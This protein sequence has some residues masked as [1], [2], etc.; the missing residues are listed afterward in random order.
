MAYRSVSVPLAVLIWAATAIIQVAHATEH[1]GAKIAPLHHHHHHT[2]S[3]AAKS[4]KA[5]AK[6]HHTRHAIGHHGNW[7]ISSESDLPEGPMAVVITAA[8]AYEGLNQN[9]DAAALSKLFNEQLALLINPQHT[10]WCAAFAN[11]IL[12]QTG[13]AFSGS[14]ETM[15]FMRYGQPVKQPAQGDIV[16]LRGVSRRSLTHVG[17]LVGSAMVNGQ[18]Y[19]KVLGGNQSNS[20]RVSMFAASKVIA[21]RRAT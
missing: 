7:L 18:L 5:C 19:Y 6:H 1:H 15:S 20:V 8:S 21:I 10:A 4:R 3:C 14:I 13:H 11:A 2:R 12:V 9:R 16:I 17:F